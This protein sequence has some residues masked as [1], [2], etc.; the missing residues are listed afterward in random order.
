MFMNTPY[1]AAPTV[2]WVLIRAAELVKRGW[3]RKESARDLWERRVHPTSQEACK[4]C[5]HGA[6]LRAS[7]EA[8][9]GVAVGSRMTLAYELQS[10]ATIVVRATLEKPCYPRYSTEYEENYIQHWND[11]KCESAEMAE[12]LFLDAAGVLDEPSPVNGQSL[13]EE[14]EKENSHTRRRRRR[15]YGR[16]SF[17]PARRSSRRIQA[18]ARRAPCAQASRLPRRIR[19]DEEGAQRWAED[20]RGQA[21]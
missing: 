15:D 14:R 13:E 17:V 18:R 9:D 10:A 11:N 19:L 5:I 12:H 1:K 7:Y 6:L 8:M 2:E 20:R 4:F 21:L 3:T 16:T